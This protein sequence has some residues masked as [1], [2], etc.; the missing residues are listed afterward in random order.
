MASEDDVVGMLPNVDR[1]RET[2]PHRGVRLQCPNCTEAVDVPDDVGRH[3]PVDDSQ[4]SITPPTAD[5]PSLLGVDVTC[6]G[7][8]NEFG[9][10]FLP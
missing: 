3:S 1:S 2:T 8:G 6:D 7:C 10:Y 4:G 9:V 5:E